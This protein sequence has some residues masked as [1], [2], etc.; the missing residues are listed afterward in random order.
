MGENGEKEKMCDTN[1]KQ[2]R[3]LFG[4]RYCHHERKERMRGPITII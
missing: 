3:P 4:K 1:Q 2:R